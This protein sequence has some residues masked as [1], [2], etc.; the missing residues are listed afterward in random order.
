MKKKVEEEEEGEEEATGGR[1][2]CLLLWSS[3]SQWH[4]FVGMLVP[5]VSIRGGWR[6]G[7]TVQNRM[8]KADG[9]LVVQL[10]GHLHAMQ[11]EKVIH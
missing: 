11:S 6:G 2:L 8:R 9:I 4:L 7:F 10:V 1:L 3:R 5:R